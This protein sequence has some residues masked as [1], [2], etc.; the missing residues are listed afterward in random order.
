MDGLKLRFKKRVDSIKNLKNSFK[1]LKWYEI[2][3][4]IIMVFIAGLAVYKAIANPTSTTSPLW[5][6]LVNFVSAVCG[7]ICIFFC[8]KANVSNFIFGLVNTVVYAIYLL[9]YKIYGTFCLE[10]LFYLPMNIAS[11]INWARHRDKKMPEK[12]MAK[13]LTIKQHIISVI[14]VLVTTFVTYEIL[15]RVGGTVAFLDALTVAIGIIATILELYRYAEQ[16]IWWII[17]DI[18][19]V[20]MY[21]VHFDTVYLTKKTIYL[22]MAIIGLRN[23]IKL[24]KERNKK[25]V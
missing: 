21:I 17:T 3:M 13:H 20:I 11:W 15:V 12:T 19:A 7:I 22:I 10:V 16:Y 5:L 14:G 18:I 9:Y 23:W 4:I 8:A 1:E 25:N 24:N 6:T 2:I